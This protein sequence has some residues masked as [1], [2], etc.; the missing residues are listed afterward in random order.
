M[1]LEPASIIP[2]IIP[3]MYTNPRLFSARQGPITG[4]PAQSDDGDPDVA[5]GSCLPITPGES[6]EIVV[7]SHLAIVSTS[8]TVIV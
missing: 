3:G 4:E 6:L 8:S 2:D 1:G 7:E 5:A